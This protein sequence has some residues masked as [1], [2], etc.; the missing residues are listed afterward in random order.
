MLKPI[1]INFGTQPKL[2]DETR[3]I[4]LDILVYD[5]DDSEGKCLE[6][7]KATSFCIAEILLDSWLSRIKQADEEFN[8]HAGYVAGQIQLILIEYG[9][10]RPKVYGLMRWN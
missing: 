9:K 6:N 3:D 7:V 8:D 5:E 2:A 4:L 10:K 1:L